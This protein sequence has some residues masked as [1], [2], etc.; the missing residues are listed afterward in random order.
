MSWNTELVLVYGDEVCYEDERRS[1]AEEQEVAAA[2]AE[3]VVVAVVV[4]VMSGGEAG[5]AGLAAAACERVDQAALKPE[6]ANE[7]D[8]RAVDAMDDVP[9][10]WAAEAPG[11]DK[12]HCELLDE[13]LED[14]HE[15]A[16][17]ADSAVDM[18]DSQDGLRLDFDD[19][20]DRA[21]MEAPGEM[22]SVGAVEGKD[23]M[24]CNSVLAV[25]H[26]EC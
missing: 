7:R 21:E 25:L 4:G 2:V 6:G 10:E 24:P 11:K 12:K 15:H 13:E 22:D 23:G 9:N 18:Q 20:F 8:V 19:S 1:P 26:V 17:V 5:W 3:V 14:D 16:A